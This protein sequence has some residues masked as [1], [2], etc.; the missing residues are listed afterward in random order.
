MKSIHV[1]DFDNTLFLSPLPNPKLWNGPTMGQLQHQEAFTNGGWWHNSAILAATGEGV[2]KEEARAWEGWWNELVVS[3]VELSMAQK[4]TLKVL[5]T[6]RSVK[7]FSELIQRIVATR[8]L[9][10]DMIC[11][12]PEAGPEGEK[13]QNTKQFK[14]TLLSKMMDTYVHAED[15]KIYEDRLGHVHAFEQFFQEYNEGMLKAGRREM[16]VDIVQVASLTV[17]PCLR[18][19]GV[20]G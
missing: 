19:L 4:D 6:G 13:I 14:T 16:R 2:A 17:S 10:F 12:K 7:G 20:V 1:Y 5:L 3:L 9:E 18:Q 11:L 15:L 8:N